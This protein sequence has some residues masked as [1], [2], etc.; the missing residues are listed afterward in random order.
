MSLVKDPPSIVLDSPE[1]RR[2]L[3]RVASP[4][5]RLKDRWSI[6][7]CERDDWKVTL[8]TERLNPRTR[9]S[10]R[11]SVS[12]DA[13]VSV[14]YDRCGDRLVADE[15]GDK[16]VVVV[17]RS[18]YVHLE[19]WETAIAVRL[20]LDGWRLSIRHHAGSPKSATLGLAFA[21]VVARPPAE[22]N[23]VGDVVLGSQTITKNGLTICRGACSCD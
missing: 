7:A 8:V 22:W 12:T 3:R 5:R 4:R 1:G 16:R 9:E 2:F 11:V 13:V 6:Y 17:P 15:H 23:T 20:L 18:R 19:T 21:E 10:R 14:D